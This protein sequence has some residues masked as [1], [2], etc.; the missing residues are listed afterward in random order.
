M[1]NKMSKELISFPNP[2]NL[3]DIFP[4][5]DRIEDHSDF[6][7]KRARIFFKCN[8]Y[9]MSVV[10]GFGTYGYYNN[11]LEVAVFDENGSFTNKFYD[12]DRGETSNPIGYC[13]EKNV[14]EIIQRICNY[15][16]RLLDIKET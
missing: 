7:I 1:K 8:K 2:V 15:K 14:M 6:L 10:Y 12:D 16:E 9:E 11:L 5:I 4:E 3:L 13:N